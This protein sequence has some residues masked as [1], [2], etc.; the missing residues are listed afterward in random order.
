MKKLLASK[1]C[2][3]CG[4]PDYITLHADWAASFRLVLVRDRQCAECGARYR[5][6]TSPLAAM[7][8]VAA[9]GFIGAGCL[10]AGVYIA[11]YPGVEETWI[12]WSLAG[13]FFLFAAAGASFLVQGMRRLSSRAAPTLEKECSQP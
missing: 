4:S 8:A 7:A 5:P 12:R 11:R 2:P 9:G 3:A 6:P 10:A 1:H 13:L